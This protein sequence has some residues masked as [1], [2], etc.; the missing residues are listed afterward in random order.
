MKKTFLAVLA[1]LIPVVVLAQTQQTAPSPNPVASGSQVPAAQSI[2]PIKRATIQHLIEMSGGG[3]N[4]DEM[5]NAVSDS[6]SKSLPPGEYR[7]KLISLFVEKVRPKVM[8]VII[9]GYD[10]NFSEEELN[11]LIQFYETP[12]GRKLA[13][14]TPAMLA[15]VRTSSE[16]IG[17]QTM[18]EILAENP[19]LAAALMKPQPAPLAPPPPPP[20]A[21]STPSSFS[22]PAAGTMRI[23]Q[24]GNMT[25]ASILSQTRPEYPPL[26]RQARI[27]GNVVLH[28]VIDKEGKV[29][30][31]EAISGHPLLVQSAMDAVRQWRYKPT[32]LNG[33]PV[34]VDTTITVTFTMADTAS[35]SP[36]DDNS[37]P[38][39]Q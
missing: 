27:Q 18:L 25:A 36:A 1:M 33:Q 32:L 37:N 20:P 17:R 39:K 30:Q 6:L 19:D 35:P 26:A 21:S 16:T 11:A 24:G 8:D 22:M 9:V 3:S 23:K 15:D 31:L 14:V 4:M 7:A 28:V 29:A 13:K 2:D 10:K 38:N 34:E 5:G 12:T